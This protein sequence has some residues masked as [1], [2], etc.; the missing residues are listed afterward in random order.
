[1][2]GGVAEV[3]DLPAIPMLT[4]FTR[5]A[6]TRSAIDN[7]DSILRDGM[8]RGATRL[9]RG[10]R[11]VVCLFDATIGELGR[12]LVR[13]NRRRYEPFGGGAG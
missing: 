11:P 7:L 12:L 8:I 6:G 13:S 9:I 10:K 3:R 5:T 1:M 2:S 4:H